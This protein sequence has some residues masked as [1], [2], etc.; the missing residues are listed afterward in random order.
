MID[1]QK[2]ET[3]MEIHQHHPNHFPYGYG[4]WLMAFA[5]PI[6]LEYIA[7]WPSTLQSSHQSPFLNLSETR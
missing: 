7:E 5:P 1:I 2:R 6:Q 3:W 4:I